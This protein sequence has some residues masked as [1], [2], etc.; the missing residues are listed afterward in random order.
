MRHGK[1]VLA[2][3]GMGRAGK[4]TAAEWFRDHTNLVYRGGCS[5]TG[6]HYMA[7]RLSADEDRLVTPDEAYARRHEDR[8]KWYHYLNDYRS[9]DSALLIRDCLSHSDII[10]GI[11]DRAELCAAKAEGLLDL[12]IWIDRD[13]PRDLT[14]TFSI[15]DADIVVRNHSTV[16]VYYWRLE[17]LA[18]SLNL[19]VSGAA[20]G[21]R[22]R[23]TIHT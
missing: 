7:E 6:R 8:L 2:F 1:L 17:R 13:V 22:V 16:D 4:D 5:W 15:E 18:K 9:Q 10:C 3:V 21:S 23:E 12:V 14:V 11:R 19:L 20:Y